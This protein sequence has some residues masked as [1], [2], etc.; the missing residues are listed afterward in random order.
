MKNLNNYNVQELQSN[1][2]FNNNGG[3]LLISATTRKIICEVTTGFFNIPT[4]SF[5]LS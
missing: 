4:T 1:E 3:T 5:T 2:L